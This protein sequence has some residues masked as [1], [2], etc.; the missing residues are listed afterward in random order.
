MRVP[1]NRRA[2]G[3]DLQMTA[4]IDVVFLL[5]VF[6]LWTS[7]FEKPE[8]DLVGALSLPPVGNASRRADVA[9]VPFDEIVVRVMTGANGANELR[10]ND[11]QI[12]DLAALKARLSSIASLGAQPAVIVHP[13]SEISMGLAIA[14]YDVA[15]ASGFDRVLFTATPP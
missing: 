8:F 15:R 4:M 12:D 5:L 11:S 9:P 3:V 7:S 1:K 10:L 2:R 14:V 13:E 6:F